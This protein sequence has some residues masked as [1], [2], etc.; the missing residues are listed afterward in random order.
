MQTEEF[1]QNLESLMKLAKQERA[2][3][4]C[5]EAAPW[6]CHR[7]LIAD[8]LEVHG[9]RVE[10]IIDLTRCKVHVM[11]P[12]AKVNGTAIM[13]PLS[14]ATESGTADKKGDKQ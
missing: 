11:T 6:R 14:N 12:F 13:Y 8:A 4:M 9:L 7:S 5:A 3:L 2:A 1:T 10:E